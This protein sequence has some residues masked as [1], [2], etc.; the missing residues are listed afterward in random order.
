MATVVQDQMIGGALPGSLT[1]DGFPPTI[2]LIE[3]RA[4][5][6]DCLAL[7]LREK[8]EHPVLMF[9]DLESWKRARQT[10]PAGLILLG[11]VD[12]DHTSVV[13][14]LF[15][16]DQDLPIVILSNPKTPGEIGQSLLCGAKGYIP[17]DTP[18]EI[19]ARA[20]KLVLVGGVFVPVNAAMEMWESN[21]AGATLTEGAPRFTAR[22]NSV[23]TSLR[24]GMSNKQIAYE[25]GVSESSV[26]LHVRKIMRK[27]E[28]HN[29]TEAVVKLAEIVER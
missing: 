22:E 3:T 6:R 12:V 18:L 24:R 8:L 28:A 11:A 25:L 16:M 27:L 9:P 14:E 15:A 26:K 29:R 4:F 20:V 17:S 23:A 2:V 1:A 10:V 13:A 7:C 19:V 21:S 5:I